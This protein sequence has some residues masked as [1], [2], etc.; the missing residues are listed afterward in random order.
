MKVTKRS[1]LITKSSGYC[2]KVL[3]RI[4]YTPSELYYTY[5]KYVPYVAY[6]VIFQNVDT[7]STWHSLIDH[8]RIG[9]MRKIIGN[10]TGH[11]LKDAKFLKSNNFM[12]TS[13]AMRKLILWPSPLKIHVESLRFLKHIQ[14]DICDPI[15][16]LSSHFRYFM[17]LIDASTRWS[18]VCLLS[19]LWH[20][21][22]KQGWS[23]LTIIH[24]RCQHRSVD[25]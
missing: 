25:A 2:H 23:V 12:C 20:P 17:V 9:M 5:I 14:G 4:P 22:P 8:P 1:L 10:C 21:T 7:F 18:H 11:D 24:T 16:P 19:T 15:Q 13:C 6:K 3:E